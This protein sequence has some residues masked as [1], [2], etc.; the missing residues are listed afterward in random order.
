MNENNISVVG[1]NNPYGITQNTITT[2][3]KSFNIS[4]T[5]SELREENEKLK[6]IIK[7]HFPEE[8]L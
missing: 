3:D 7:K 4:E 5:I 2:I 6:N 1:V 8:F